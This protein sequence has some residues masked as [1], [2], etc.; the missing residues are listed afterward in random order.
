MLSFY[1]LMVGTIF[2]AMYLGNRSSTH[3]RTYIDGGRSIRITEGLLGSVHIRKDKNRKDKN[4]EIE[5]RRRGMYSYEDIEGDGTIDSIF[6]LE[7]REINGILLPEYQLLTRQHYD[8]FPQL[9]HEVEEHYKTI[10]PLLE[11]KPEKE[12]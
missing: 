11:E 7:E 1:G 5:V 2:G 8:R 6:L 4:G 10:K 3:N 12:Q 9:F